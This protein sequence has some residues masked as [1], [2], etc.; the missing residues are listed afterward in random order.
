[1]PV[2]RKTNWVILIGFKILVTDLEPGNWRVIC[3]GKTVGDF[4]VDSEAGD[5][6]FNGPC[7]NY[8]IRKM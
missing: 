3:D 5:L 4:T 7:G 6:Y 8:N 1:M 2:R